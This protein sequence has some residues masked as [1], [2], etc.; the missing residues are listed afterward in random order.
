MSKYICLC[1]MTF[2]KKCNADAHCS[3]VNQFDLNVPNAIHKIF[4]QHW[5]ASF[6]TWFF[7]YQW[8]R[9]MRF[10]G[11]YIIYLVLIGHFHID[12]SIWEAMLIGLGM[13]LYIK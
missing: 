10:T 11:A 9:F 7:N 12:W 5:E 3:V 2:K 6:F 13:G 1:G 8:S 4:K